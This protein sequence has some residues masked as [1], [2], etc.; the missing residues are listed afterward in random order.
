M[1]YLSHGFEYGLVNI[2]QVSDIFLTYFMSLYASKTKA[3]YETRGK[4]WP[5]CAR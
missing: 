4:C 1:N 3:K 5:Y 2:F